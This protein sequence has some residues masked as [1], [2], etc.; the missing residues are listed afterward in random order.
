[1]GT[2]QHN[3]RVTLATST[4]G[5]GGPYERRDVLVPAYADNPQA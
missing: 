5:A 1:M 3:Q 4:A 2:W